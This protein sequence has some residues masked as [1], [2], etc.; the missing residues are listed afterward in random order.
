MTTTV[1]LEPYDADAPGIPE[2]VRQNRRIGNFFAAYPA[3]RTPTEKL[4]LRDA[5]E[6]MAISNPHWRKRVFLGHR[7]TGEE[8][9]AYA[10]FLGAELDDL[11]SPE[12]THQLG[13][14]LHGLY[15]AAWDERTSTEEGRAYIAAVRKQ[16]GRV[17]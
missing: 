12:F 16:M 9:L 2:Y 13:L 8:M 6:R 10:R 15:Q 14:H 1:D 3:M 11:V 7:D 5:L 17:L 4:T